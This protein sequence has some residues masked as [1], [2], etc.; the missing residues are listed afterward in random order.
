MYKIISLFNLCAFAIVIGV[1]VVLI[2]TEK[3]KSF[4]SI[5]ARL[6][7]ALLGVAAINC[8]IIFLSYR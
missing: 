8:V 3:S 6:S 2:T 7:L 5:S 4:V 1:F